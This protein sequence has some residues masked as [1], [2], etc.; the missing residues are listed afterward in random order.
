MQLS[1]YVHPLELNL[2]GVRVCGREAE[3]GII[4]QIFD[5]SVNS[6]VF[7]AVRGLAGSGKPSF[8]ISKKKLG[9]LKGLYLHM[10]S[11]RTGDRQGRYLL[12]LT[13]SSSCVDYGLQTE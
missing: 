2:N 4:D 6:N 10:E 12:W 1:H 13:P 9:R 5:H 8:W 7:V 3:L 11:F